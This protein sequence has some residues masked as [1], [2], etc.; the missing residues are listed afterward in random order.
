MKVCSDCEKELPLESFYGHY[1]CCRACKLERQRKSFAACYPELKKNPLWVTHQRVKR[2]KR[3][4]RLRDEFFLNYGNKCVCCGENN[5]GFLTLDHTYN[6]GA[7]ERGAQTTNT[8]VIEKL[9][10]EGWPK[11]DRYQIMCYNCNCGKQSNAGIC[12]HK[13]D[14]KD[15]N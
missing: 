14:V 3:N 10:R 8:K 7:K 11:Q 9:Y 6:D 2:N 13:Q 5:R 15:V 12:P 4:R 1:R